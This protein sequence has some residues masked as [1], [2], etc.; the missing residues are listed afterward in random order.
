MDYASITWR[1]G[2]PYCENFDDVYYSANNGLAESEYVFLQQNN[3]AARFAS[4]DHFVIAETGFGS[5]LNFALTLSLWDKLAPATAQLDYFGIEFAPMSPD[6]MRRTAAQWPHLEHYFTELLQHYPLPMAGRHLCYLLNHR[7]RLHLCYMDVT[8]ALQEQSLAVDA[9][10]LDGFSP[11]KNPQI[12]NQHVFGLLAQNSA[13]NATLATYTA[14]GFVR[15]GL[16]Q[17]GFKVEKRKGH[18]NKREMISAQ[19]LVS[20]KPAVLGAPWLQLPRPVAHQKHVIVLGA[21]LAGLC[22]ARSLTRRGWRVSLIDQHADEAAGASGNPVGLVLPRFSVDDTRDAQFYRAA[23]L[24]AI[25]ELDELQTQYAATSNKSFWNRRGVY[26]GMPASR[27]ARMLQRHEFHVDYIRRVNGAC[28]TMRYPA[29]TDL[30]FVPSAGWA[31]PRML[32]RVMRLVCGE[33]LQYQHAEVSRLSQVCHDGRVKWQCLS[34]AGDMLAEAEILVLA[35]GVHVNKF[36]Q[37][38]WLPVRTVRGQLTELE[39]KPDVI[40]PKQACSFEHYLAPS[41][42]KDRSYYCGASYQL[43]DDCMQLRVSDQ[44][45]NYEF[46]E[47]IYP[48]MFEV[49]VKL[50]GR[51]GFRA[52]SDDRMPIVGPVPDVEWFEN[53]YHDL[54]YGRPA[55]GYANARYLPGLFMTAAH[56][57]RGMTSCFMSAELLAAQIEGSPNPLEKAVV[58]ALNPARFIIRRLK[59]G[60]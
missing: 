9:W 50:Q 32:C 21:G 11:A 60:D 24:F 28:D 54:R 1:N 39:L 14:A 3:L 33:A 38:A 5:G 36:P 43:D 31:S 57:S 53:E 13:L 44:Q 16:E 17:A 47:N 15:R 42:D 35:N 52:V 51:T 41:V 12:F 48:G 37:T 34:S 46:A 6:D 58:D 55:Q 56:G 10:Y 7:V 26:C 45:N 2:Q 30:L 27:A 19:F 59:R 4:A 49:P 20:A 29:E 23:F 18:G 8:E 25:A 40:A 22:T